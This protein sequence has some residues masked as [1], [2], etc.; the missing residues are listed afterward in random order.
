MSVPNPPAPPE[1]IE[2][3]PF[4]KLW[5]S[6]GLGAV[7]LLGLY[8]FLPRGSGVSQQ[9]KTTRASNWDD[10]RCDRVLSDGFR[11]LAPDRLG[12]TSSEDSTIRDLNQWV[13]N[14]GSAEPLKFNETGLD[15]WLS[16][17]QLTATTADRF[18]RRDAAHVRMCRLAREIVAREATGKPSDR[19][20]AGALME[21]VARQTQLRGKS[22]S[23]PPP[24]SPFDVLLYGEGTAAERG[25]LFVELLRQ[26][27]LDAVVLVHPDAGGDDH[28]LVGVLTGDDGCLLFDPL[29]GLPIPADLEADAAPLLSRPATWTEAT[30][31]DAI[32]RAL[33]AGESKHPWTAERLKAADVRLVGTT[34]WWSARMANLQFQLQPISQQMLSEPLVSQ[35]KDQ[36][37]Y[38]DRV[39][40]F[41]KPNWPREKVA[42]WAL[43]DDHV[44]AA[45]EA[46]SGPYWSALE[47]VFSG[48]TIVQVATAGEQR[49]ESTALSKR[50]LKLIR[51]HQLQ[52]SDQTLVGYLAIRNAPREIPSPENHA[53]AQFANFW[54]GLFQLDQGKGPPGRDTLLNYLQTHNPPLRG[55]AAI[56]LISESA[57]TEKKPEGIEL[58]GK[59]PNSSNPLR[60]AVLL[61]HWKRLMPQ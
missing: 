2:V 6:L 28:P 33:D 54:S 32:F 52:G 37:G 13:E 60:D 56:R 11:S 31:K 46:R 29:L 42:V 36:D 8:L 18:S 34:S 4:R 48:P 59:L 49:Q 16:P 51:V 21:F 23:A 26:V 38:A 14:C 55:E 17:A 25:W 1:S 39:L 47:R 43:P 30:E 41:Q 45:Q 53:A 35:G 12:I 19:E 57:A 5:W 24:F 20:K 10:A 22:D 7:V 15:A 44:S 50:P 9:K 61:K 40:K 3:N 58:L 27:P